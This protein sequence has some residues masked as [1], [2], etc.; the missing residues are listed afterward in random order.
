VESASPEPS[1]ARPTTHATGTAAQG[2]A[3]A[4]GDPLRP[5]VAL[6]T[7]THTVAVIDEQQLPVDADRLA[8]LAHH[9]LRR[10]DV[11]VELELS[12]TCV[13][14]ERIGE[15]NAA[16]MGVAGPTDVLAFPID[17]VDDVTPGV[18]GLLGDVVLC[19]AVAAEQ[20]GDHGRSAQAELD[21]LLVHGVLH[22]LGH[23]HAGADE[24]ERMFGL[25]DE[26]LSAFASGGTR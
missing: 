11:P 24:R 13:D 14:R 20:A 22:L 23:D 10:L 4:D 26:L 16:H 18:P 21:L 7:S 8:R 5:H 12:V 19:P 17:D 15:L 25:T 3:A 1:R 2:P 6:D 9:V